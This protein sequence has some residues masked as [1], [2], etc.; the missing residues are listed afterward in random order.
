MKYIDICLVE[1]K[2]LWNSNIW[3]PNLLNSWNL[4]EGAESDIA[5][6]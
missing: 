6:A 2:F 3:K 5:M 4:Q 1:I